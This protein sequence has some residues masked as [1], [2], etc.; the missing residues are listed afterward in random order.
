MN[1]R[2]L[3]AL[4]LLALV[5]AGCQLELP[6]MP[7]NKTTALAAPFTL[8]MGESIAVA[9]EPVSLRLERWVD[10]KRCP[11]TL[12]CAESGPVKVQIT[13][14]REGK[15]MT[16]PVFIAHTDQAGAVLADA[17]GAEIENKVGRIASP[18]LR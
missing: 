9:D 4:T 8:R 3:L 2:N 10:D 17:P 15:P 1:Y 7:V 12:A 14:W 5:L 13:F 6:P 18:S 11:A 16:Y